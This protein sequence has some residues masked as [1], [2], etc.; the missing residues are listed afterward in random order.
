[1]LTRPILAD[2]LVMVL[3]GGLG[4]RLYPLTRDRAKPAV[5]FGGSY[6]IID[7]ALSNCLNSGL[8]RVHVLTQHKSDS[9]NRHIRDAWHIFNPEL[10]EYID[11]RPPQ[12]RMSHDWY[13]GTAHAIYENIYTLEHERPQYVLV[14]SAD[15]V[16]RMDYA[17]LIGA[18]ARTG[19]DVTLACTEVSLGEAAGQLGVAE[20][21]AEMHVSSF[22]EK[23][24]EPSPMPGRPDT[25]LAS[26]GIYVFTTEMLVRRVIDDAKR[27]TEHDFGLNVV[28]D[29]IARGDR[30][31]A[32]PWAGRYWRDIGTIDAYWRA[33][34]DLVSVTPQFDLYDSSWPIRGRARFRPP[35]KIVFGSAQGEAPHTQVS[36]SLVCNGAIVSGAS[37]SESVVGP[38]SH[39][40][41][42]SSVD[43]SVLFDDVHVGRDVVIRKTVIDK[44]NRVPEG[45]R[46]GVDREWDKRHFFV[47]AEG[48]VVV[49][50]NS[51]FPAQ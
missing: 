22:V 19:A 38:D 44:H 42:G 28:P 32:F 1:V 3:A 18:H 23:P 13:L 39:V 30:V 8:R 50:K 21:D 31:Y 5:P 49:P 16:H 36:N 20:V 51:P 48:I 41:V 45:A 27:E 26:M 9:L 46:L 2:T 33:H 29:M 34:M 7:F 14:L 15:H 12:Q 43:Q 37:V 47:S 35:A 10:G 17:R 11:I 40:E 4:Q 24:E 6:R 25:C